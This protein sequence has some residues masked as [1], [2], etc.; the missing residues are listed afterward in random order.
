MQRR[1]GPQ[2]ANV[3]L[4]VLTYNSLII[5]VH[6]LRW[7]CSDIMYCIHRA[8]IVLSCNA[9]SHIICH[10]PEAACTC[11]NWHRCN[12]VYFIIYVS[13]LL[14]VV[15]CFVPVDYHTMRYIYI[16]IY[17]YISI[18]IYIFIVHSGVQTD[19]SLLS[20]VMYSCSFGGCSLGGETCSYAPVVQLTANTWDR[21][22]SWWTTCRRC[23]AACNLVRPVHSTSR[24][25]SHLQKKTH[26]SQ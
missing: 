6:V 13:P 19:Y 18:Y 9:C 14:V 4:V 10:H 15:S 20:Y 16:Y 12:V 21:C 26:M 8:N 17:I 22:W 7:R 11:S 3:W 1:L 23:C 25:V 24:P 2:S 5:A